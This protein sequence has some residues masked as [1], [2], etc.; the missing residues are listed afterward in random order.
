LGNANS[1]TPEW[2]LWAAVNDLREAAAHLGHQL[3]E[4][5]DEIDG[6]TQCGS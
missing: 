1:E 5:A 3:L 6:H 4:A 2:K